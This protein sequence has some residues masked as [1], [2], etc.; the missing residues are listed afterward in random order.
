MKTCNNCSTNIPEQPDFCLKCEQDLG[1]KGCDREYPFIKYVDKSLC[2]YLETKETFHLQYWYAC[3]ECFPYESWKGPSEGVC[4]VCAESCKKQNHSL[5]KRFGP[6]FCDKGKQVEREEALKVKIDSQNNDTNLSSTEGQRFIVDP[7]DICKNLILVSSQKKAWEKIVSKKTYLIEACNEQNVIEPYRDWNA[8]VSTVHRAYDNHYPLVLSPDHIWLVIAQGFAQH[9]DQN[10][11]ALRERFVNF[12]GK[13]RIEVQIDSFSKGNPNNPWMDVFPQFSEQIKKFIGDENHKLIMCNYS[14]TGPLERA[15]SEI[16][17]MDAMKNY[18]SYGCATCCGIPTIRLTGK[19]DD[20]IKIRQKIDQL[21][22]FDL[23]WWTDS[24][25]FVID[26]FI[27]AYQGIVNKPFWRNFY[28]FSDP[29]SGEPYVTGWINTL[30]PY[31]SSY[32]R[33]ERNRYVTYN[34]KDRSRGDGPSPND[35]PASYSPV[36]FDWNYMGHP[37]NMAFIGG[38]CGSTQNIETFELSPALGWAVAEKVT[39]KES[40]F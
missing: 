2:T 18:F 28:K 6:F 38:F 23:S 17:L 4:S 33:M 13:E 7:V 26:E 36:S 22:T 15:V 10:S 32:D 29:G 3:K 14:T 8:F 24:L 20:W 39:E 5:R 9:I 31:L 37:F 27:L 34:P 25:K 21:E 11:E 19:L 40:S 12:T 35:F 1:F 16:V 30:F